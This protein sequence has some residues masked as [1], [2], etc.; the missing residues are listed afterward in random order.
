MSHICK[1]NMIKNI[2]FDLGGV[3]VKLD[4]LR[5]IEAFTKIG[6]PDF[7]R[8]INEYFQEGF[9]MDYEKGSITTKEFRDKVRADMRTAVSDSEIDNAMAAFLPGIPNDKLDALKHYAKKYRIFLLS[10]TN[11]VA[12]ETVK[13]MFQMGGQSMESYFEKMYLSYEMKCAKPDLKIFKMLIDDSGINPDETLFVD[14]SKV[15]LEAASEL[16]IKTALMVQENN[17]INDLEPYL[18]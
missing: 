5:C 11:P 18:C 2:I 12:I 13:P 1:K 14:D 15:N 6:H 7:G 4:K 10:N 16:G 8:V 3:L 17:L 9:F